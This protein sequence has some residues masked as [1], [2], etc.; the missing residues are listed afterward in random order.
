[1]YQ[2]ILVPL[3]GSPTAE[4][5]IPYALELCRLSG[6][7][8]TLARVV[9]SAVIPP[10]GYSLADA[11]T[12][13]M[14]QAEMRQEAESYLAAVAARPEMIQAGPKTMVMAGS[15]GDSLLAIIQ[16]EEIDIVVMTTRQRPKLARWMLGSTADYLVQHAPIPVLLVRQ[17]IE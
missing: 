3:N 9:P 1:M 5:A 17:N 2:K 11:E 16:Q 10:A 7:A 8:L 12:W 6:G 4:E 14:R 15:V 13:L